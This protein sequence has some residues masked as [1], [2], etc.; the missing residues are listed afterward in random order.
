[1]TIG[2]HFLVAIDKK[3]PLVLRS[4]ERF[5]LLGPLC[6]KFTHGSLLLQDWKENLLHQSESSIM[7]YNYGSDSPS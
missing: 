1:M 5:L 3:L 7:Y 2:P 6:K 4:H